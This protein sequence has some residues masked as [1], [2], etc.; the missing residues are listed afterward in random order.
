MATTL[1]AY[2]PW[3]VDTFEDVVPSRHSL[4]KIPHKQRSVMARALLSFIACRGMY[5]WVSNSC[6]KLEHSRD[7]TYEREGSRKGFTS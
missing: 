7:E 3:S 4:S 1:P 6:T 5:G 2:I